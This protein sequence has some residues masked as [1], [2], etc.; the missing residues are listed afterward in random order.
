M[1]SAQPPLKPLEHDKESMNMKKS[2][3]VGYARR[4]LSDAI[5]CRCAVVS[6]CLAALFFGA[7]MVVFP[8]RAYNP[9]MRMLSAL[10]H[11]VIALHAFKVIPFV[12]SVPSMQKLVILSFAAWIMRIQRK[13]V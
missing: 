9:A 5:L 7:A 6:G 3:K 1:V 13:P 2:R 4:V 12:P 8:G 11:S 10:G